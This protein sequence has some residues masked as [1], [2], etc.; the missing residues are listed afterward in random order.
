[1]R[2]GRVEC[3]CSVRCGA[4]ALRSAHRVERASRNRPLRASRSGVLHIERPHPSSDSPWIAHDGY[5]EVRRAREKVRQRLQLQSTHPGHRA[6]REVASRA[7]EHKMQPSQP[8]ALHQV[9]PEHHTAVAKAVMQLGEQGRRSAGNIT[10]NKLSA[11]LEGGAYQSFAHWMRQSQQ[12]VGSG[13]LE[14]RVSQYRIFDDSGDGVLQYR[15]VLAAV[16]AFLIELCD[17]DPVLTARIVEAAGVSLPRDSPAPLQ[18]P[19]LPLPAHMGERLALEEY[20]GMSRSVS[21]PVFA[22]RA[23]PRQRIPFPFEHRMT[24]RHEPPYKKQ[25]KRRPQIQDTMTGKRLSLAVWG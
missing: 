11:N 14:H 1:M 4:T 3:T 15:E 17:S 7:S 2:R 21:A 22:T 18:S 6:I 9:T 16:K 23:P 10:L 8:A 5:G 24:I 25:I 19:K 20:W 12:V 13:G